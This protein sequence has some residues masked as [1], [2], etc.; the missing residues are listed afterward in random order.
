MEFFF[1]G[2]TTDGFHICMTTSLHF[3]FFFPLS[4]LF[5]REATYSLYYFL[6]MELAGKQRQ[7]FHFV[8]LCWIYIFK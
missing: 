5:A 8:T 1:S 7:G 6:S 4:Y 2:V 3:F